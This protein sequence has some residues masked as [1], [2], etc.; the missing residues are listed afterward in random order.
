MAFG[1]AMRRSRLADCVEATAV[2]RLSRTEPTAMVD[3][4]SAVVTEQFDEVCDTLGASRQTAEI[5][6]GHAVGVGASVR[7]G[8]QGPGRIILCYGPGYFRMNTEVRMTDIDLLPA[9]EHDAARAISEWQ[10]EGQLSQTLHKGEQVLL[11]SLGQHTRYEPGKTTGIE[12]MVILTNQRLIALFPRKRSFRG[13]IKEP[14]PLIEFPMSELS[15]CSRHKSSDSAVLLVSSE[16]EMASH[17]VNF[18][19]KGR[20]QRAFDW[21]VIL[22]IFLKQRDG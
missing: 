22:N 5:L 11:A 19:D 13:K 8:A 9:T 16:G 1:P 4:C 3:R 6:W 2:D 10:Y 12:A 14:A 20:D 18:T 7:P 21:M 15:Q 17:V